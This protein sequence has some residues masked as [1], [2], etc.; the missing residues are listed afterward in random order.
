[1]TTVR[2]SVM[3]LDH[4]NGKLI[5]CVAETGTVI[6]TDWPRDME[7]DTDAV[8]D[9]HADGSFTYL[10]ASASTN[11]SREDAATNKN[12]Y[13]DDQECIR[14]HCFGTEGNSRAFAG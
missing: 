9:V 7:I 3:G 13:D 5:F 6:K 12:S 2:A 1:M 11:E 4:K 10:A 14:R 8:V